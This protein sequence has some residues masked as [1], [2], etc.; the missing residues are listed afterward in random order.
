MAYNFSKFDNSGSGAK[1]NRYW[2]AAT[3]FNGVQ[4]YKDYAAQEGIGL[5]KN[6]LKILLTNL[7]GFGAGSSPMFNKRWYSELPGEFVLTYIGGNINPIAGGLTALAVV[8]KH[9]VDVTISYSAVGSFYGDLH[10]DHLKETIYHELTHT[11]HYVALGGGWYT[12]FVNSEISEIISSINSNNSPY[13]SGN[14]ANSPIIAVGESWAYHI[15]HYL[16]NKRYTTNSSEIYIGEQGVQYTNSTI[17]GLSSH[18][19]ALENFNP[20]Y[21]VDLFRWIPKGIYYDLIDTRNDKLY[22]YTQVEDQVST[23]TNQQLFSAF[24]SGIT[25]MQLYKTNVLQRNTANPSSSQL[26]NL[27]QQYGY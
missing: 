14:S 15:G 11:A 6:G 26:V 20:Y 24:N 4:E 12:Q 18:L 16:T 5:P 2:S 25:T 21:P 23:F 3:V 13:G 1:G 10:S 19:T 22:N 17:A 27:F 7:A 9:E 8:L